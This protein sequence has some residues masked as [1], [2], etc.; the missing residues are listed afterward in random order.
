MGV[1][2]ARLFAGVAIVVANDGDAIGMS[3]TVPEGK[4]FGVGAAELVG[5][6]RGVGL[7]NITPKYAATTH[8]ATIAAMM[9]PRRIVSRSIGRLRDHSQYLDTRRTSLSGA[10]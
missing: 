10:L 5:V 2:G 4:P 3:V 9:I 7:L 1:S 8:T 6:P